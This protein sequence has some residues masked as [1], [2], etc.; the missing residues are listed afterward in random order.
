MLS[1]AAELFSTKGYSATAMSDLAAALGIQ[2]ASLYH[3]VRT[4]ETLLYE[5]SMESMRHMIDAASSI[6]AL[7]PLAYL[8]ALI[9]GHVRSLLAEQNKHATALTELRSLSSEERTHVRELRDRYDRIVEEAIRAVQT[10]EGRWPGLAP[11]VV[12]LALLGMLNWT[13]FWYHPGGEITA[14]ELA[15]AYTAIFLGAAGDG[16]AP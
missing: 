12:R 6:P 16:E 7:P 4:K 13:V 3:H 5:L 9:E 14:E 8:E 11:K 15:R 1:V 2:K 10:A